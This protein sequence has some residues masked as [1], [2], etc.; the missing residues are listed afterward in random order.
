[1]ELQATDLVAP[2]VQLVRLQL[3][4][5]PSS[6]RFLNHSHFNSLDYILEMELQAT[7]LLYTGVIL[8]RVTPLQLP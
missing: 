8:R 5:E 3:G 6:L 4:N 2:L 1:M 7:D